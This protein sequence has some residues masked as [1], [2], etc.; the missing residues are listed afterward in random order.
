MPPTTDTSLPRPGSN[1]PDVRPFRIDVPQADI[2]DLRDRLARTRWPEPSPDPGWGR[3]VPLDYLQ[4]LADRW[5][6]Q[7]EWRAQ[8]AALNRIP[9]FTTTIDGQTIHFLHVRSQEPG[10][11]PLILSHGYPG[12]FLDFVGLIGPLTDPRAHGGDPADAFHVVIPSLP[13]FGFSTPV[14]ESGWEASRTARAFAELMARLGYERYGVH[15]YDIGAGVSGE[16]PKS[17][18]DAVVGVHVASELQAIAYLGMLPEPAEDA[19]EVERTTVERLRLMAEDGSGYLRLQ[20]TRPQSLAYGLSDSPVLQL[21]WIAEKVKEWTDPIHELPE[22]AVDVDVLLTNVTLYW[23]TRSGGSAA[24]FMWEASHAE[25]DWS[26]GPPIPLGVSVFGGDE[27]GL[28]RR[29]LDPAGENPHWFVHERGGH[30][31]ALEE[32]ELLLADLRAFFG[33]LR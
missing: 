7:F 33:G 6:G 4:G 17:A 18:P 2:D 27:L 31:P 22:D 21:A 9:Q 10:A 1:D 8:E 14:L 26:P 3:G 23:F 15:G 20:S 13:G 32:P 29:V 12:S 19:P 24:H 5:R 16:L 11:L 25:A 28:L 30:F